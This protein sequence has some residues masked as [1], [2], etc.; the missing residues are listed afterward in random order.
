MEIIDCQLLKEATIE[1]AESADSEGVLVKHINESE[2]TQCRSNSRS[3]RQK[4]RHRMSDSLGPARSGDMVP[5]VV[6][7]RARTEVMG[8]GLFRDSFD[9]E[10][11]FQS[12]VLTNYGK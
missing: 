5:V 9:R 7:L 12:E 1:E 8:T 11:G 4:G 6:T 3:Q 10:S 2:G